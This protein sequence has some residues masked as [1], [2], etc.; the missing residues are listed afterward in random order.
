MAAYYT[1]LSNSHPAFKHPSYCF[2]TQ[3]MK[4]QILNTCFFTKLSK[5]V[6]NR[7]CAL[8][9]KQGRA[10]AKVVLVAYER[11]SHALQ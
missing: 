11:L 6:R 1:H 8:Y 5:L 4:M 7:R 10:T 2:M 9:S 3:I